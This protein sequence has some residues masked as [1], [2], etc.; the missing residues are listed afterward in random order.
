MVKF[1]RNKLSWMIRRKSDANDEIFN[2]QKFIE[3]LTS[4]SNKVH[5]LESIHIKYP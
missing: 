2:L 5:R 4:Y 3:P 1:Y